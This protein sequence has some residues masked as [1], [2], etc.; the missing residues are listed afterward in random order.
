MAN[1]QVNNSWHRAPNWYLYYREY[2]YACWY[3]ETKAQAKAVANAHVDSAK[4]RNY[5]KQAK[6]RIYKKDFVLKPHGKG[7]S[8][9]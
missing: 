9:A 8:D 2:I 7:E 4:S 5:L 6:Y 3:S 1:T